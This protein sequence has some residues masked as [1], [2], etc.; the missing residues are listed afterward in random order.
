MST[1]RSWWAL[2]G[3]WA[4]DAWLGQQTRGHEDTDVTVFREDQRAVFDHLRG[5][6]LVAHDTPDAEHTDPWD[7]RPLAHPAHVHARAH[8]GFDLEV[9]VNERSADEWILSREP[10]VALPLPHAAR[11]STWDLPTVT[12]EVVL[13]YKATAYFGTEGSRDARDETDFIALLPQVAETQRTW[14]MEAITLVHPGHP[15]LVRFP[16]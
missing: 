11:R 2:C 13:F 16:P 14:L 7:G 9:L 4:V 10:L 15:W 12:P 6:E 5:W 8:D 1:F 3:G